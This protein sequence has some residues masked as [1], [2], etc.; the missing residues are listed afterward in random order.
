MSGL[1]T[2]VPEGPCCVFYA[3]RRPKLLTSGT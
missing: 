2:L 3:T 1:G